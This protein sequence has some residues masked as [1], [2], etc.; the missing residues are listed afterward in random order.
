MFTFKCLFFKPHREKYK[1]NNSEC[2][3]WRKC[4][5]R[6]DGLPNKTHGIILPVLWDVKPIHVKLHKRFD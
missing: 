1:K 2:I 5:R 4:L 6:I 3:A